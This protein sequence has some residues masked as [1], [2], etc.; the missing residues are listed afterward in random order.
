MVPAPGAVDHVRPCTWMAWIP[1]RSAELRYGTVTVALAAAPA[2][3][4]TI[5]RSVEWDGQGKAEGQAEG[6]I[7]AAREAI[8]E[9]LAARRIQPS[10]E[11]RQHRR[12]R[13]S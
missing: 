10:P 11:H 3:S 8:Y 2:E 7:E 5:T 12:L 4:V 9:V 6:R 1:A 13:G